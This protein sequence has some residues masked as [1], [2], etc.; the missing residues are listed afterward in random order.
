M[1]GQPVTITDQYT[2]D[3]KNH[4]SA[5]FTFLFNELSIIFRSRSSQYYQH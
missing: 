2:T 3:S 4:G 5:R 1:R